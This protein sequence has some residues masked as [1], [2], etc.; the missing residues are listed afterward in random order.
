VFTVVVRVT[1]TATVRVPAGEFETWE[2]EVETE[3]IT[4]AFWVERAGSKRVIRA[5]IERD[6]YELVT[7]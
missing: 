5:R 6:L 1:G 4:Q 3:S 2:I 7:E